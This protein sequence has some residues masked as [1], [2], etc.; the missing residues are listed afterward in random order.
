MDVSGRGDGFDESWD[1]RCTSRELVMA[2]FDDIRAI[3]KR[4]WSSIQTENASSDFVSKAVQSMSR[5]G[6]VYDNAATLR[7]LQTRVR[8]E[9]RGS[10]LANKH[11][12][13]RS[14]TSM[15]FTTGSAAGLSH[16]CKHAAGV[17]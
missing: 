10:P 15:P 6:D 5:P 9:Q 1:G 8:A 12:R 7:Q 2:A 4:I 3:Q 11:G 17:S 16:P 13:R 14:N